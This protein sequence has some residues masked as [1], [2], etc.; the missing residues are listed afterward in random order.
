MT[1]SS[2]VSFVGTCC[3]HLQ[4]GGVDE[5]SW[6]ISVPW[7]TIEDHNIQ[8][9]RILIEIID[10]FPDEFSASCSLCS[11]QTLHDV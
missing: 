4:D 7:A 5:N 10:H 8:K 9:H 11:V 3:L 6:F 1:R 2:L